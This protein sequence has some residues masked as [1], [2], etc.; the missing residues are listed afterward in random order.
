MKTRPISAG[1]RYPPLVPFT[2]PGTEHLVGAPW[3][4]RR[5]HTAWARMHRPW[6]AAHARQYRRRR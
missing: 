5:V 1:R 2:L 3:L 6:K 4:V